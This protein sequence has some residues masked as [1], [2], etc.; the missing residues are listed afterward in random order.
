VSA[1]VLISVMVKL[2]ARETMQSCQDNWHSER[3][4]GP[5]EE[6]FGLKTIV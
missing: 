4:E 6:S 5:K 1:N 3:I 2:Q